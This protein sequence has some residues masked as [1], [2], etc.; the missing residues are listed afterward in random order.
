M[1][2]VLEQLKNVNLNIDSASAVQIASE[3]FTY[4]YV[5]LGVTMLLVTGMFALGAYIVKKI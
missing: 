1:E 4:K 2:E 5:E 3:Y